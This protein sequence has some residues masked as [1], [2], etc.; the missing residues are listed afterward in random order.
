MIRRF[1]AMN[2]QR[3]ILCTAVYCHA[4]LSS[5]PLLSQ[6]QKASETNK[7]GG[8]SV[9]VLRL[10][11]SIVQIVR[12]EYQSVLGFYLGNALTLPCNIA[13]WA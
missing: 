13:H 3:D 12:R 7:N 10:R 9:H 2:Q 4:I 6:Q 1:G 8:A 11:Y 5:S